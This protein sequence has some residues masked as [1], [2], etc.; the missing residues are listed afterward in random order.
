MNDTQK[1]LS[2]EEKFKLIGL[3]DIFP[4]I[5]DETLA[6]MYNNYIKNK[7]PLYGNITIIKAKNEKVS[8]DSEK[9]KVTINFLNDILQAINHNAITEITQFNN[10]SK[11]ELLTNQCNIVLDLHIESIINIFGKTKINY[12]SRT[13][14]KYYV[15]S[16]IKSII[17]NCGYS[18]KVV[19]ER[20]FDHISKYTNKMNYNV[21]YTVII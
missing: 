18:I 7:C 4:E 16:V 17:T 3:T 10:V 6:K 15:I 19:R 13:K 8:N 1:N 5:S 11:I 2:R 9:Y 14:M 21:T 20:K 12:G